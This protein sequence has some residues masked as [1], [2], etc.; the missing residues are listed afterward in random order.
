MKMSDQ[1]NTETGSS[2]RMGLRTRFFPRSRVSQGLIGVAPWVN[3]VLLLFLFHLVGSRLVLQPGVVV[4]L[5]EAPF[6]DGTRPGL[7][8]VILPVG[9][10]RAGARE[11]MIF[12]DDERFRASD[13]A[14]MDRLKLAL[15]RAVRARPG[16]SL[17]LQA[18]QGIR[19]GTV[20][21]VMNMALEVGI[22]SVN[23]AE[24]PRQQ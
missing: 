18:D 4:S 8:A 13:A 12:F 9:S 2:R 10:E 17:I 22:S 15:S 6:T 21:L 1:K 23:I 19:H 5:P 11:E 16:A 7:M 20:V 14:Q 24:R 3:V